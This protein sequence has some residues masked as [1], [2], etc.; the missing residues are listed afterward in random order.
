MKLEKMPNKRVFDFVITNTQTVD[1]VGDV[2]PQEEIGEALTAWQLRDAP[3]TD[4]HSNRV[5]GKGLNWQQLPDGK[6]VGRGVIHDGQ[7]ADLI[8][9][10]IQDGEYKSVSIGG[11]AFKKIPNQHGGYDLNGLD[12]LEVSVCPEGAHQEAN[13]IETNELAKSFFVK[14]MIEKAGNWDYRYGTFSAEKKQKLD[15]FSS[16]MFGGNFLSLSTS[17]QDKVVEAL[18]SSY[19]MDE[20][21]ILTNT[22]LNKE[23]SKAESLSVH[24]YKSQDGGGSPMV[25]NEIRKEDAPGAPSAPVAPAAPATGMEGVVAQLQAL[26]QEVAQ[27]KQLMAA[28]PPMDKSIGYNGSEIAATNGEQ[29]NLEGIKSQSEPFAGG[30]QLKKAIDDAVAVQMAEFK[31]GMTSS[32]T[33]LP[34][35]EK[36][37]PS[38][39]AEYPAWEIIKGKKSINDFVKTD[40]LSA[41]ERRVAMEKEFAATVKGGH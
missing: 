32:T 10:K 24:S 41:L 19:M 21:S 28:K 29:V 26:A 40:N 18:G 14:A 22:N 35:I 34:V 11:A 9:K 17:D 7:V 4:F 31:K 30:A 25:N 1:K 37:A 20:K 8:W 13:I 3:I 38:P 2:V 6:I 15:S 12:I 27:L 23:S 36:A 33:P 39:K 5:I 16:Q